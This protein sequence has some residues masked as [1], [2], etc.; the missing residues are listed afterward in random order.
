[1][2]NNNQL[3]STLQSLYDQYRSTSSTSSTESGS[4]SSSSLS[5]DSIQKVAESLSSQRDTSDTW[6]YQSTDSPSSKEAFINDV[7]R[8]LFERSADASE[9]SQWSNELAS[10]SSASSVSDIISRIV[11]SASE[12]EKLVYTN[13]YYSSD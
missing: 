11:E 2:T 4:I 13:N 7:Y 10:D 9:I 5:F 3:E 6:S 8:A 1:M 12:T